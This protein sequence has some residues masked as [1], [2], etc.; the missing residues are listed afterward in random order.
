MDKINFKKFFPGNILTGETENKVHLA[1]INLLSY[2]LSQ[3]NDDLEIL[4]LQLCITTATGEWLEAWGS[5]FGVTRKPN[6]TDKE[7]SERILAVVTTPKITIPALKKALKDYLN[8]KYDANYKEDEIIIFEPYNSILRFSSKSGLFSCARFRYADST[9]YRYGVIDIHSPREIDNN[10]REIIEKIKAAGIKVHYTVVDNLVYGIPVKM[11]SENEPLFEQYLVWKENTVCRQTLGA[12]IFSGYSY[13]LKN[14]FSG[15]ISKTSSK[16]DFILTI[17]HFNLNW[18]FPNSPVLKLS[19]IDKKDKLTKEV[20]KTQYQPH[21]EADIILDNRTEYARDDFGISSYCSNTLEY[22]SNTLQDIN[23]EVLMHSECLQEYNNFNLDWFNADSPIV[24][25]VDL[26][27]NENLSIIDINKLQSQSACNIDIESEDTNKTIQEIVN[28]GGTEINIP[29]KDFMISK[30]LELKSATYTGIKGKTKIS[31]ASDFKSGTS[32]PASEFAIYNKNFNL[33][34]NANADNITLKNITFILEDT[35]DSASISTLLG[36]ANTQQVTLENCDIIVRNSKKL[37]QCGFDFYASNKNIILNNCNIEID[38]MAN[39]GGNWI[40]N[41]SETYVENSIVD[42][43]TIANCTFK[44]SSHDEILAIYGWKNLVRN[45]LV[46]D[47]KFIQNSNSASQDILVSIFGSD[48]SPYENEHGSI[49]NITFDNN[50]FEIY[51]NNSYIIQIGNDE[52]TGVVDTVNITNST[53]NI[54]CENIAAIRSY[55]YCTNTKVEKCS[56]NYTGILKSNMILYKIN[57][58]IGNTFNTD[59]CEVICVST[60][61]IVNE[62]IC[63]NGINTTFAYDCNNISNNT[64]SCKKF[65]D[66]YQVDGEIIIDSNTVILTDKNNYTI[67]VSDNEEYKNRDINLNILNNTIDLNYSNSLAWTNNDNTKFNFIENIILNTYN[68]ILVEPNTSLV[69]DNNNIKNGTVQVLNNVRVETILD[70]LSISEYNLEPLSNDG[71][72]DNTNKLQKIIDT[73]SN[74]NASLTLH[75][76]KEGKFYFKESV[77]IDN[78]NLKLSLIGATI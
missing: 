68:D 58:A 24:R 33:E 69:T 63:E 62:N 71:K 29:G 59:Y 64:A 65:C 2:I 19:D 32:H 49:N 48:L 51:N 57:K 37:G 10:M 27:N 16:L 15:F 26:N 28:D 18:I 52:N 11:Y 17:P 3:V 41:A 12:K 5:W 75:F 60:T 78:S 70:V 73:Y 50:Y 21:G 20:V 38:T 40:R 8:K 76:P 77:F 72:T 43:V 14:L 67:V 56:F 1:I 7:L 35:N 9:Y 44:T 61:P 36:F 54:Y 39:N 45:V 47:S 6:E 31:I 30:G 25:V 53:F 55:D 4:L 66:F 42:S 34:F 74:K 46:T 22:L 13:T 23:S